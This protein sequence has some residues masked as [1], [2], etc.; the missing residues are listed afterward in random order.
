MTISS[1]LNF[2]RPAPPERGSAAGRKFLTLPYNSQRV[3]FARLWELFFILDAFHVLRRRNKSNLN[4]D[5]TGHELLNVITSVRI[6]KIFFANFAVRQSFYTSDRT[7]E[8]RSMKSSTLA[9][10]C[11]LI[12]TVENCTKTENRPNSHTSPAQVCPHPH[13][14]LFPSQFEKL[15]LGMQQNTSF[16]HKKSK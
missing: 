9:A 15:P 4:S 8:C 6:L 2:G 3:V 10:W 5:L 13:N 7:E 16:W 11:E 14:K 12:A 1:W